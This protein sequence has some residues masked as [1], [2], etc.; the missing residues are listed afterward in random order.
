MSKLAMKAI[1]KIKN[2]ILNYVN[3][4]LHFLIDKKFN[5]KK[6]VS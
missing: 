6:K 4:W 1:L 3:V 5:L 2:V